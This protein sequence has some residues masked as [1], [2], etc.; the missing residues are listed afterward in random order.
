M[1]TAPERERATRL[2]RQPTQAEIRMWRL[3]YPFR[4]GG[5]HFRKQAPIGPYVADIACHHAKIVIELDGDTHFT[6]DAPRHD[7]TRDAFLRRNGYHVL[8]FTNDDITHNPDGVFATV[9]DALK[10]R[11]RNLRSRS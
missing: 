3:L 8:R 5:F 11:E 6:G 2:R 7:A 4:T 1:S 10:D 9:E